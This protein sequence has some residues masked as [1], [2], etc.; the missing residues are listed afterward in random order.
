MIDSC[1]DSSP[2][3]ITLFDREGEEHITLRDDQVHYDPGSAAIFILDENTGNIRDGQSKDF[4]RF[5]KIVEQLKYID[6]QSTALIY[7]D[8]PNNA[9]DW[10]RL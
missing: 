3:Q 10:H 6:A 7:Q 9:Q 8:V 4:I 2:H 1:L 5:S